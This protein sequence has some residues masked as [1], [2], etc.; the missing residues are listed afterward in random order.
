MR[1]RDASILDD[2]RTSGKLFKHFLWSVVVPKNGVLGLNAK[3]K[4]PN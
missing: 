1:A 4:D 2:Y 3:S